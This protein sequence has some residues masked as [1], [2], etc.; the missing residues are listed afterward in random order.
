[1]QKE[2]EKRL[3]KVDAKVARVE[4]IVQK[5]AYAPAFFRKKR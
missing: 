2:V 4:R 5:V 1:M 3:R